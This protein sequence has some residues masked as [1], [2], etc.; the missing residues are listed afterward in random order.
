[1]KYGKLLGSS[2]N[3]EQLALT[4]K[5]FALT[6]IPVVVAIA[7]GFGFTLNSEDLVAFVNTLFLIATSC[8]TAFGLARKIYWTVKK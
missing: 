3:P 1:M 6:L 5:G 7:T 4:V 2:S 8:I